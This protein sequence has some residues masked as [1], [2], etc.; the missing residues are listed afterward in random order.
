MRLNLSE[1]L[2]RMSLFS[3]CC[4]VEHIRRQAICRILLTWDKH[5]TGLSSLR[6][7]WLIKYTRMLVYRTG[8]CRRQRTPMPPSCSNVPT[9][10]VD[11]FDRAV[12]FSALP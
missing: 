8:R 12:I 4:G 9:A 2:V 3:L 1:W 7:G 5:F 10:R 6:N 11:K